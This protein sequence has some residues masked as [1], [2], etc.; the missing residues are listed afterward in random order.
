MKLNGIKNAFASGEMGCGEIK[1]LMTTALLMTKNSI[2][3]ER[4]S[5]ESL[6]NFNLSL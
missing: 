2:Y 4:P 5:I 3:S 6:S 1:K